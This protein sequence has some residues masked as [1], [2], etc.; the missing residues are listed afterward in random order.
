MLHRKYTE[1]VEIV[2]CE[3]SWSGYEEPVFERFRLTKLA[4]RP[5]RV[6]LKKGCDRAG[7]TTLYFESDV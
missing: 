6:E 3:D 5:W 4:R 2:P 7:S 1:P